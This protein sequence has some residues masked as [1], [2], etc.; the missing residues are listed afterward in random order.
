MKFVETFH[1][2]RLIGIAAELVKRLQE[3]ASFIKPRQG[4]AIESE[5]LFP[6]PGRL[7]GAVGKTE[8]PWLSR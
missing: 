7:E 8:E 5:I 1:H 3:P 4:K 2:S 6:R